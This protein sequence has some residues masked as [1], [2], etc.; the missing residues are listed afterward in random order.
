MSLVPARMPA[1]LHDLLLRH[2]GHWTSRPA[3]VDTAAE[4]TYGQ[5]A[6]AVDRAQSGLQA[7][8]LQR[9]DRV[10]VYL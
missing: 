5:L 6:D 3:L 1:L 10:A 2:P 9:G 7:L 8:A 4:L